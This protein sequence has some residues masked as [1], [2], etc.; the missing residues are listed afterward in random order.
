MKNT[1][2]QQRLIDDVLAESASEQFRSAVLE[3]MLRVARHQRRVR[4]FEKASILILLLAL[5][6]WWS[7][8]SLSRRHSPQQLA[9]PQRAARAY[10]LVLSASAPRGMLVATEPGLTPL[11]ESVH[12]AVAIVETRPDQHLF[13][14]IGDEQLLVLLA[15]QPAALVREGASRATVLFLDH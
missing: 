10:G 7:S 8:A 1:A 6:A 9:R 14:E 5:L 3:Q 15:G 13:K 11:V 4:A 12:S 2:E